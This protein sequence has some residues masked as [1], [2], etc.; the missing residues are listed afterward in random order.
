M[1]SRLPGRIAVLAVALVSS[2]VSSLACAA[3]DLAASIPTGPDVR[4][5]KLPNGLTY[6]IRRNAIPT[7]RLELRLVVKAGSIL[8][9][10]DQRGLA[11]FVEHMAFNGSTH[12]RRHEVVSYLQSIGMRFG[13]DV[14]AFTSFDETWYLLPVPTARQ[15]DIAKGFTILEDWAHGIAFND[16]D[17]DRERSVILEESRTHK[18]AGERVSRAL[19]PKLFNGSRYAER[20][21]IGDD[22]LIRTFKPDALRRFYHDW[23]RPELMA[24]IAVG[25]ADP[26]ELERQ[27]RAHF[28]PLRNPDNA[29][30]RTWEEIRPRERT[31]GLVVT[32]P[33]LPVNSVSLYYPVRRAAAPG[34]YGAYRDKLLASLSDTMLSQRLA[35]LAQQ[36][37]PPFLSAGSSL[38]QMTPRYRAYVAR[39]TL[40]PG[41]TAPALAA[42]IGEQQRAR[43]HGFTEAELDRARKNL[44]R[45]FERGYNERNGAASSAHAA[46]YQRHFLAGEAL[47]GIEA[48]YLIVQELLPAITLEQV[49]AWMRAAIPAGAG[50]LVA[51]VGGTAATAPTKERL[52]AEV[53][54][55]EQ[56]QLAAHEDNAVATQ[57]MAPPAHPG[58]IVEESEDKALGIARL[59]FSNGVRAIVKPTGFQQDQVLLS[60]R[61]F[62]GQHLFDVKDLPSARYAGGVVASMGLKDFTPLDLRKALAGRNAGVALQLGADVD[63]VGGAAGSKPDDIEAML[64]MVWLRFDGV[65]RDENLFKSFMARQ[66]EALRN[67]DASPQA[68]F[69]DAL[70]D[71]IYGKHPYGPRAATLADL[72]KVDLDRSVALY[73]QRFASARGFTFVIV[74]NVDLEKLKPLLAA[75]LGSLPTPEL[76]LGYRDVG[77]RFARGVVK[78]ELKAGTEPRSTVSLNFSGPAA[79]SPA[80]QLRLD[81]LVEVMNLRIVDVLREKMGVIYGGRMSGGIARLPYEHYVIGTSLPTAPEQ[82]GRLSAALFAEIDRLKKEGPDPLEL[83]KVKR[84]WAES[85][86]RGLQ[87]NAFW[88]AALGGAE[89]YGIDPHRVLDQMQRAAALTPDDVRLAAQRYF[90]T[91]NYVQVVL[92]PEDAK[93]AAAGKLTPR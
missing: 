83:D 12:F 18:G 44:L 26:D 37:S 36:A 45:A 59:T 49:N 2:L 39:A 48:E 41:G 35:E 42:L 69:G 90:D 86:Q 21:A 85:W 66:A 77:L 54:A 74:G 61:R 71:A 5:G 72:A 93:P 28:G 51:Y 55:A 70:V 92:N 8:E 38:G 73:R 31:E 11:H 7:R 25:D 23:Y 88:A 62:G 22:D 30:P 27:I 17:I 89:L 57:L 64:Q 16:A 40:G 91:E 60:A 20:L 63:E 33:E 68:R 84:T 52:L 50:K 4:I 47:P 82:V 13:A 1:M 43:Q 15:E 75:Y 19:M 3:V 6:Y 46:D 24:V 80:E 78:R 79:W 65:R 34:T 67:R 10:D 53:A 76:P 87:T 32:D 29:R 14:N 56:V 9:D 81:A 58:R